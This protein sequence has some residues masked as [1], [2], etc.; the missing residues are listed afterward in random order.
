MAFV[1]RS[2]FAGL[3]QVHDAASIHRL[4]IRTVRWQ[5]DGTFLVRIPRRAVG[6]SS[7]ER[8]IAL[9]VRDH[10]LQSVLLGVHC[11]SHILKGVPD[12]AVCC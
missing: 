5:K 8:Q 12:G 2:E 6:F 3:T 1:E 10:C 9:A 4:Q 7:T 11:T